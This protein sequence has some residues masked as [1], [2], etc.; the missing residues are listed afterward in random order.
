MATK[1]NYQYYNILKPIT[2]MTPEQV[3]FLAVMAFN[4]T[5]TKWKITRTDN[6]GYW[7]HGDGNLGDTYYFHIS[8][9]YEI[10]SSHTFLKNSRREK[11]ETFTHNIG[12]VQ[13][14]SDD[15]VPYL[16][17]VSWLIQNKFIEL[18][19]AQP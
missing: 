10:F 3:L 11:D 13:L 6:D 7:L 1:T 12:K 2:T 17:I 8:D 18:K 16:N 14:S 15:G 9:Y 19:T 5:T 4:N